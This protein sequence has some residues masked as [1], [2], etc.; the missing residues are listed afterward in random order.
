MEGRTD[1]NS[2]KCTYHPDVETNLRCSK[3]GKPICPRCLVETPVGARC[4]DCARLYKLPTFNIA[5]HHYMRAIGVGVGLAIGF[6]LFWGFIENQV[7][8]SR[9]NIIPIQS[10][11]MITPAHIT[12]CIEVQIVLVICEFVDIDGST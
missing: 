6:G 3:C 7:E 12:R 5:P 10:I 4:P 1:V 9:L 11:D 8:F 2:M